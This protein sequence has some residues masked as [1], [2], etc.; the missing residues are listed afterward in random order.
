VKVRLALIVEHVREGRWAVRVEERER[1]ETAVGR[2]LG[3]YP[4][5]FDA[6][7]VAEDYIVAVRETLTL[8]DDWKDVG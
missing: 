6:V 4:T 1:F 2:H 5:A 8:N 3:V 7:C